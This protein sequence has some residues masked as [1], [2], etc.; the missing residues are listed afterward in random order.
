MGECT[1]K[2]RKYYGEKSKEKIDLI[3]CTRV[4]AKYKSMYL[5]TTVRV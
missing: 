2:F 5:S 4:G 1:S 3:S